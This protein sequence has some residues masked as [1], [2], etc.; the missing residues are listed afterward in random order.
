MLRTGINL[1][2]IDNTKVFFKTEHYVKCNMDRGHR[3]VL[4]KFRAVIYH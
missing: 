3:R 1:E 4:A 2:H